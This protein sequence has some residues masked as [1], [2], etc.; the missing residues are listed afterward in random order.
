MKKEYLLAGLI[1]IIV[2]LFANA[3]LL[4]GL[5]TPKEGLSFLGRRVINS[6]DTYTYVSFIEQVKQGKV[7]FSNLYTSEPQTSTLVRPSYTLLGFIANLTG[8]TSISSYHLGRLI[9]SIP[10]FIVLYIFIS[11]FFSDYRKRLLAFTIT[12]TS[13]GVGYL[14]GFYF[15]KSS[16]S[17]IPES[18]TFLS[19]QEAPHFILS[20]TFMLVAFL[21]LLKGFKSNRIRYFVLTFI[22]LILLGFEH[23]YNLLICALTSVFAGLYFFKYKKVSLKLLTIGVL[24]TV[25]PFII[26][27]LYQYAETLRNPTLSSWISQSTSPSPIN[28][29][30]GYGILIIF[31]IFGLE[32]YLSEKKI[33]QILIVSWIAATVI[34]LYSP[35]FFQRRLSEGLHIPLS[36]LAAEGL[37][38]VAVFASRFVIERARKNFVYVFIVVTVLIMAIGTLLGVFQDVRVIG[39]DS[40]N[41][42]YYYLSNGE[43]NGMRWLKQETDSNDVILANW[44][45]GNVMPGIIGRKVYL[46][47]SAQTKDFNSKIDL[48]NKFILNTKSSSAY[49]FL[50]KNHITYIYLGS[51]DSMLTYGFKPD[52]KPYLIKVYD[53]D[54]V[55]IYEV[56]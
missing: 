36:I 33:P 43:V 37:V 22:A 54:N 5:F 49:K 29:I 15:T 28:Y 56:R 18:L 44:F 7:L 20:Q 34:L 51:N 47:H 2:L 23:P 27:F 9:F 25:A 55:K 38:I 35:V 39:R 52:A 3:Y 24:S 21:F 6:Q 41:S 31:A 13:T 32:K 11:Q 46:G 4:F 1:S 10:F 30:F 19:L 42:Y 17:W 53:S 26:S 12:L 48:V 14:L 8:I 50:K 16:D 40:L 45:Y